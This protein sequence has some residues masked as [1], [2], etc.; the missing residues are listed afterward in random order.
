VPAGVLVRDIFLAG[1]VL[2]A[3]FCRCQ[4]FNELCARNGNVAVAMVYGALRSLEEGGRY[5]KLN[6]I[7]AAA[8]TRLSTGARHVA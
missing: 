6:D 1:L 3:E 4:K 5:I 8:K 2:F 7:L